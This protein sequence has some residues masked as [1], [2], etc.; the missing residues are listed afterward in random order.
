LEF[1]F[2]VLVSFF[3]YGFSSAYHLNTKSKAMTSQQILKADLLDILFENRN[4]EYGAYKL[5]REYPSHLKKAVGIM[6]L[7]VSALFLFSM[8]KPP[9][10]Q[11][12]PPGTDTTIVELENIKENI[13]KKQEQPQQERTVEKAPPTRENPIFKIVDDKLITKPISDN[14]DTSD[15]AIGPI[16]SPGTGGE[17]YVAGREDPKPHITPVV[18]PTPPAEPEIYDPSA[19]NEMPQFPGGEGAWLSYLQRMLRTPDE[20]EDGERK[21]VRVKFVVNA[22]GAVTD[23]EIIQ[24]G[25]TAFDKEVLRVINRMPKWKPGKQRGKPVAVYFTQ[26]VTFLGAPTD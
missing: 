23:A 13:P 19:V 6:L 18:E 1:G 3:F 7:F 25:G 20:L 2:L 16:N 5:R 14:V 12:N 11:I 17:G 21:A 24:S 10:V 22:D 26:P 8:M 9:S 15:I 4:K